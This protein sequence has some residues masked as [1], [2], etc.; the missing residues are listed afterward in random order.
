M[1]LLAA[2]GVA[3]EVQKPAIEVGIGGEGGKEGF[4]DVFGCKAVSQAVSVSS[5]CARSG[6]GSSTGHRV[7]ILLIRIN[8]L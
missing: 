2:A 8:V 6:A 3:L 5:R 7:M 1:G 4:L